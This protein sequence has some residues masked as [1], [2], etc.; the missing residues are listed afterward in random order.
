MPPMT[1]LI[2]PASGSCNMKCKYCFYTDEMENRETKNYGFMNIATLENVLKKTIDYADGI[3][4][5]V[6]QGGEPTLIGLDYF[7]NFVSIVNKFNKKE[8]NMQY[9]LQTNGYQLNNSWAKFFK[10]NNFLIGLSLDGLKDIHNKYRLD[11]S[12]NG[13]F[14][15]VIE[16]SLL[17]KNHEVDFNILTVITSDVAK[18]ASEIYDFYK[19]NNLL[20]QQ[21]I[22]CLEPL[23]QEQ[24][25]YEHSLSP[26]DYAQFLIDLFD[27]WYDDIAQGQ[28]IYIQYFENIMGILCGQMPQVCSMVG[29]C[30]TY[31]V[32][33]ADG[34]AYPCDFYALDEYYLG[35]FNRQSITDINKKRDEIKFI[36]YS[37][38][39][40]DECRKCRWASLCR[41][42]CRRSCEPVS[43]NYRGK[44]Y[45][46]EAY[47]TFFE[48]AYSKMRYL[49]M[50]NQ[51]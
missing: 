36:E 2:K 9:S 17:L 47:K 10:Q 49:L 4:S 16:T 15:K 25:G 45:F 37:K 40:N 33:E 50:K 7:K 44:N 20:Y 8:C 18:R 1:L 26:K 48:H 31:L 30:G 29:I 11:K 42:G 22:E 46:C 34:S 12:S 28:F 5:I 19:E 13:S 51:K 38:N 41:N 23:A 14:D 24:W 43:E 21:Y 39:I 32:V 3:C 35:N 27:K 6:F